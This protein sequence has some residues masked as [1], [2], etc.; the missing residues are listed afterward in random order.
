MLK[1][2]KT[3]IKL[4]EKLNNNT[5][6]VDWKTGIT[7]DGK[8]IN[9]YRC[10]YMESAEFIDSFQWKHWKNINSEPDLNNAR[11]ELIDIW[12]FILSEMLLGY[13]IETKIDSLYNYVIVPTYEKIKPYSHQDNIFTTMELIINEATK[14]NPKIHM[15]VKNFF[16]ACAQLELSFNDLYKG[17]VGKN[18]LNQF[19]QDNGYKEGAYKKLWNGR[20]DNVVM[21]EIL[22]KAPSTT[23]EK[24]YEKL[25]K[26]YLSI[27]IV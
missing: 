17:Y 26:K 18:V 11:V 27:N 1:Q 9:W 19:R 25:N 14:Q 20:E 8:V 12:H 3:M 16:I 10:I 13:K 23:P 15:I 6:G 7:K 22:N 4:Q 2:L 21:M 5:N 24:L